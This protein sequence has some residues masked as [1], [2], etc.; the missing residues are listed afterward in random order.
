VRV[1]LE[2]KTPD[3]VYGG[4]D[5]RS[6]DVLAPINYAC[7]GDAGATS[8]AAL[9]AGASCSTCETGSDSVGFVDAPDA[10][11]AVVSCTAPLDAGPAGA[12]TCCCCR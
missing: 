6:V 2:I 1:R 5:E 4:A 7:A 9:C 12:F 10:S 3:G 8:C 11:V